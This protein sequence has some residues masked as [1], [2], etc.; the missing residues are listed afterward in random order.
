MINTKK[1]ITSVP[2]FM[3]TMTGKFTSDY[4]WTSCFLYFIPGQEEI[5][6]ADRNIS[7]KDDLLFATFEYCFPFSEHFCGST[8]SIKESWEIRENSFLF[9][10]KS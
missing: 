7:K 2:L 8:I 10:F 1:E 6:P 5:T 9:L 3:Q 4:I